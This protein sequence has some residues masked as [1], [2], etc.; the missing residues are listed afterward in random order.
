MKF[1][2]W[3]LRLYTPWRWSQKTRPRQCTYRHDVIF[4]TAWIFKWKTSKL[5]ATHTIVSRDS[6]V[7]L[8]NRYGLDGPGSNGGE[9]VPTRSNRPWA[10][11]SSYTVGKR[12]GRGVDDVKQIELYLY[13]PSGP[14][15]PILGW[16]LPA[17]F[18]RHTLCMIYS[19]T[20]VHERPCS[21]TIRFTNK[22]SDQ[23]R[24]GWQTVSRMTN[25]VSDYEHAS[26]QQRQAESIGAGVSVA[27]YLWLIT[28]PCLYSPCLLLNFIMFV[29]FF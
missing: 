14:S 17:A 11:L 28:H 8:A 13:S 12:P 24:L 23:K 29:L 10:H 16:T 26:W 5:V 19:G 6:S 25:G 21:R 2:L 9:I 4:P 7:G 18:P 1:R 3:N 20:S 15:W 27:G 22:F